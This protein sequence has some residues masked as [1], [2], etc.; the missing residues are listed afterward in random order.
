MAEKTAPVLQEWAP[1]T[2]C[3]D[4]HLGQLSWHS[5]GAQSFTTNEVPNLVNQGGMAAY[6]AA[7]VLFAACDEATE[8]GTLGDEIFCMEMALGLG[9]FSVQLLDRFKDLCEANDKDW[10]GRITWFATDATAKMLVD[11][12][13]NNIFI[14]HQDRV[15]LGLVD[16][17]NPNTLRRLDNGELVDLTGKLN[18]VF[19]SYLL[20]VLPGNLYRRRVAA[21]QT[22]WT[23]LMA[24][25]V[26]RH[27]EALE[28]F[29][30]LS[31]NDVQVLAS[32]QKPEDVARLVPLYP[33]LDLNLSLAPVSEQEAVV[34]NELSRIAN[35]IE[36]E[37]SAE[38]EAPDEAQKSEGAEQETDSDDEERMTWVLHSMGAMIALAKS[39]EVLAPDGFV[40]YRDYGPA[41]AKTATSSHLYQHYGSSTAMGINHFA[42]DTW[43]ADG[44]LPSSPGAVVSKAAGDA[45]M[46]IKT[47]FVS[48]AELPQTRSKFQALFDR[49]VL[50]ELSSAVETARKLAA[51]PAQAIEGYRRA[52]ALERD[53]WVLLTEAGDY[54]LRRAQNAEL[55]EVLIRESLRINPWYNATA[56]NCLGD[57]YWFGDDIANAKVCFERA[58]ASNPE[59]FLGWFNLSLVARRRGELNDAVQLAARAL[60][61]HP[62]GKGFERLQV[63]MREC[64]ALLKRRRELHAEWRKS[65]AAGSPT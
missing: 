54:A 62:G 11:A 48:R 59:H 36:A 57:L 7:E 63:S 12:R 49:E 3:L 51:D 39:F 8:A 34:Q 23:V 53:N 29:T 40:F 13:D 14:R 17:L 33:L 60:A 38:A 50:A 56:W 18:A 43:L 61:V 46:S 35:S 52:L 41:A 10:Y 20:C 6:R 25:T 28:H 44:E 24:Q 47:R 19:H 2:H 30:E 65:R 26:L 64:E 22:E 21:G 15:V 31:I 9:L 27:P 42:L 16:A 45:Q 32:S 4:W 58:T 55:A 1:L 37:L 5:R